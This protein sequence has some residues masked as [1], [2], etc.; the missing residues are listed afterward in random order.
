MPKPGPF[1]ILSSISCPGSC[2]FNMSHMYFHIVHSDWI[3]VLLGPVGDFRIGIY[4]MLELPL[5]LLLCWAQNHQVNHTHSY[6]QFQETVVLCFKLW[7]KET[8]TLN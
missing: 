5:K 4:Q 2:T 1:G 8:P 3:T 7:F 6:V